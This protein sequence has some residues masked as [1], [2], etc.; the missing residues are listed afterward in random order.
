[1]DSFRDAIDGSVFYQVGPLVTRDQDEAMLWFA[2]EKT[3]DFLL[4][5][6]GRRPQ[7]VLSEDLEQD[8]KGSNAKFRRRQRALK[9]PKAVNLER[10][11][12]QLASRSTFF[13]NA[14]RTLGLGKVGNRRSPFAVPSA[15]ASSS[16]STPG[17][18]QGGGGEKRK[19]N[20]EQHGGNEK[21]GQRTEVEQDTP[22]LLTENP[23]DQLLHSLVE[24]RARRGVDQIV[25]HAVL[26]RRASSK[27]FRP[28]SHSSV[29]RE[30]EE[31]QKLVLLKQ[32]VG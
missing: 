26:H 1:M 20:G 5:G 8:V 28:R 9:A 22:S 31:E 30:Q 24:S 12:S 25:H 11:F 10:D 23:F 17:R 14:E 13:L 32:G 6:K 7:L 15:P 27:R 21:E 19:G 2:A 3:R 18:D 29:E 4:K 16:L